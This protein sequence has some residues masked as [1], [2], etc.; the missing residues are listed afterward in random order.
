MDRPPRLF[1]R[2]RRRAAKLARS[3][4][5]LRSMLGAAAAKADGAARFSAKFAAVRCELN[6]FISL[7]RAW[8]SGDYRAVSTSA[9]ITVAAAVLYFLAPLDLLPDFILGMGLIDDVAVIGYVLGAVR[10]EVAAFERW[11]G[12]QGDAD[13]ASPN[14]GG[15]PS[16]GKPVGSAL[17]PED[18]DG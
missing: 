4:E 5:Q 15:W 11:R 8:T 14:G 18:G 13:V 7:L 1:D 3:P 10:E 12:E 2:Y 9:V 16:D 6:A 17:Q